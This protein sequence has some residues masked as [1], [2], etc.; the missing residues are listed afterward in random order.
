MELNSELPQVIKADRPLAIIVRVQKIIEIPGADRI[1]LAI[2]NGWQCIVKK[3]EFKVGDFAIYFCI[4]SIPDFTDPNTKSLVDMGIS[5]IKT[6]KMRGVISQ[7]L[8]APLSWLTDRGHDI[9]KLVEDDDV[10][11]QMG[12][13]KYV[14]DDELNQYA[15]YDGSSGKW[16]YSIP[17]TDEDR[18]QNKLK[19]L[20]EIANREIIITRKEDG[21]S[22]TFIFDE[23]KFSV[24]SR[25]FVISEN[26]DVSHYFI[27]EKKF[28]I[29]EKMTLLGRSI[30]IQGEAI[31]PKINGNKLK[32]DDFTYRVF[33]IFDIKSQCYLFHNEVTKICET[34][35]LEQV[36]VIYKGLANELTFKDQVFKILIQDETN[37]KQIILSEF[38]KWA[39]KLEYS[40][41]IRAEGLVVKTDDKIGSRISF[42]V[43]SNEFLIAND[44]DTKAKK[45]KKN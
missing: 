21:C 14:N 25:N 41:G 44:K 18:L 36:P 6:I 40:K 45:G 34:L 26:K 3:S 4:D 23:G 30:A 32:L 8:L 17:K 31:G 43:I 15:N 42:K 2:I 19:Y 38:L 11:E 20:K 28:N 1:V 29:C 16:P 12:V 35:G 39:D 24:C 22:C 9:S 27:L 37:G 10:T 7:G 13:T 5:R 33:N